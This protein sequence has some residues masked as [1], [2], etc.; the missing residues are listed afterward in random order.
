MSTSKTA[1]APIPTSKSATDIGF[2]LW[3]YNAADADAAATAQVR[4]L[5]GSDELALAEYPANLDKIEYFGDRDLDEAKKPVKISGSVPL[6]NIKEPSLADA[7]GVMNL[8]VEVSLLIGDAVKDGPYSIPLSISVVPLLEEISSTSLSPGA[9]F[10]L[11][12]AGFGSKKYD[13][14]VLL[15][16]SSTKAK[17][18]AEIVSWADEKI[19]AKIPAAQGAGSYEVYVVVGT[20]SR[21][22][23]SAK[24]DLTLAKEYTVKFE[25]SAGTVADGQTLGGEVPVDS[26]AYKVGDTVDV[27]GTA[28]SLYVIDA[29]GEFRKYLDFWTAGGIVTKQVNITLDSECSLVNVSKGST[30]FG[31]TR[32]TVTLK[33]SGVDYYVAIDRLGEGYDLIIPM[34]A[35]YTAWQ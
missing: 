21:A 9:S 1:I 25:Y 28:E 32:Y 20:G 7:S 29:D 30:N 8:T 4:V 22:F 35:G 33:V 27:K 2:E 24:K 17:S 31:Y 3:C 12:G 10:R 13:Q 26:T 5:Q 14:G 11:T 18:Y 19:E 16:D 34:K 23:K 15:I 6:V